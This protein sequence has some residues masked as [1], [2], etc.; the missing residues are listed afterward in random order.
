VELLGGRLPGYLPVIIWARSEKYYFL[1]LSYRPALRAWAAL[2][3][4]FSPSL[5]FK[6]K[7][8]VRVAEG[9][10]MKVKY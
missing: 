9:K 5:K 8:E 7:M 3:L 4:A 1:G 2:A 10:N 6:T